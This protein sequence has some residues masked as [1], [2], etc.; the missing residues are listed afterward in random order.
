[1]SR[2]I[3]NTD[4]G[5]IGNPGPAAIGI[6]VKIQ[7][8]K[9]EVKNYSKFIGETTNNI[10][11]YQAVIFGLNKLKRLIG[12]TK[13]RQTEV[14][15]RSDSKLIVNQLNGTYKIKHRELF[16]LFIEIWNL[17]QD[18]KKVDFIYI[19][20]KENKPADKLVK[21]VLAEHKHR[22][23]DLKNLIL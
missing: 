22:K 10:A 2:V 12:K 23:K 14:E 17:K 7:N 13:T 5:S 6:V 1:M 20:R 4:G 3:I 11:E 9:S 19:S 15:I 8:L 21:K 18:F 16:P